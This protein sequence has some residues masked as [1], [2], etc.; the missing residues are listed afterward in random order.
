[1][2]V[3]NRKQWTRSWPPKP[4]NT[5]NSGPPPSPAQ[6][7]AVAT[8]SST[9][10]LL[11]LLPLIP[12][13]ALDRRRRQTRRTRQTRGPVLLGWGRQ[14]LVGARR[15]SWILVR[16]RVQRLRLRLRLEMGMD[17]EMDMEMGQWVGRERERERARL[18]MRIEGGRGPSHLLL[19]CTR[20]ACLPVCVELFEE[21]RDVVWDAGVHWAEWEAGWLASWHGQ[22]DA[23]QCNAM[24]WNE[25]RTMQRN[26]EWSAMHHRY[27]VSPLSSRGALLNWVSRLEVTPPPPP[28][29]PTIHTRY[30]RK[31]FWFLEATQSYQELKFRGIDSF[32]R[33]SNP[34]LRF[35][36][37]RGA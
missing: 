13:T 37:S 25:V 14:C 24:Q 23:M 36:S 16:V 30:C 31:K 18:V 26:E 33:R 21:R 4:P 19:A 20:H 15:S 3:N 12:M 28:S 29:P 22:I 11:L 17:M 35:L 10:A 32:I 1:M 6:Q 8:A 27:P 5:P 2:H 9:T 34:G 7:A